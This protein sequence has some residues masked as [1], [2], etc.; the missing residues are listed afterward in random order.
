M[1]TLSNRE[2]SSPLAQELESCIALCRET[3]ADDLDGT[4]AAGALM[5]ATAALQAALRLHTRDAQVRTVSLEI[6][7]RLAREAAGELRITPGGP[8][9]HCVDACEHAAAICE[10]ALQ[11]A[12]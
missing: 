6:A 7:V 12:A 1:G 8:L 10:H 9:L 3:L 5:R 11:R 2:V 4:A